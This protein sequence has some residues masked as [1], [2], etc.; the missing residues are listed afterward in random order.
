ML[1]LLH[2]PEGVVFDSVVEL[3]TDTDVVPVI[4]FINGAPFTV[5]GEVVAV[6]LPHVFVA[7][8]VYMPEDNVVVVIAAGLNDVDEKLFGPDQK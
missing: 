1:L 5:T 3:P 6:V 4:A 7:V 2:V 8:N